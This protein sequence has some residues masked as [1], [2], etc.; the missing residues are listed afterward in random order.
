A[1][2]YSLSVD[3]G[4]EQ[5]VS[6]SAIYSKFSHK[7]PRALSTEE[8]GD[9]I[10]EIVNAAQ[11][12][13]E[14]GFDG[15]EIL[16]SAGYLI[17][18][19]LSPIKNTRTDRY[20]APSGKPTI[21][22]RLT[23]P[24]EL[25][26]KLKTT[27]GNQLFIGARFSGDD[28]VPGSNT[29][30]EKKIVAAAYDKAGIQYLN[31]T[32]GWHETRVPQIPMD[33]PRAAFAYLAKEMRSIVSI[34]VFASNRI[35]DPIL[36]ENL[37]Q[38]FYADAICFGRA[39]IA[40]PDFASKT[41][42]G[43]LDDIRTCVGCNQG[44]FDSVFK[45]RHVKCTVNPRTMF[46]DKYATPK[47]TPAPKKVIIIGA[48]PAGLEAA[49]QATLFGHQ[50]ILYEASH[51]LGGQL[52]V[53]GIPQGR[54]DIFEIKK[55]YRTQL[56]KLQIEYH[57]GKKMSAQEIL[58]QKPDVIFCSTGV[59]FFIPNIKGIDGS[60]NCNISFADDALAGDVLLGKKVVVIGGA[61]TGTETALWVAKRGAMNPN[62]AR[63]LSFH[64]ALPV[65]DAMQ[66]TY[67]GDREVYLLEIL[68][69]LGT[70]VG[71]STK[72]VFLDEL[73]KLQVNTL[74]NVK[75]IEFRNHSVYYQ[76]T[77]S[78]TPDIIHEISQ[79]DNF[80][81]ATGVR[82]NQALFNELQTLLKDA[83]FRRSDPPKVKK[84]GDSKKV[85][86][87]LDAIH[88]GFKAAYRLGKVQPE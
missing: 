30:L 85:G 18:Q 33:T 35:N 21:Q 69:K 65:E 15:V 11:N 60:Q 75:T 48:G 19:F 3:F 2:A 31:V 61:A 50:V 80:I 77:D 46:E 52:N 76:E 6:S 70:G 5:A 72:W 45:L 9:V 64:D 28:F 43:R 53:A 88:S 66:R 29:Y 16:S 23:F 54:E 39:L 27:V 22:E 7:T 32:G 8:V 34:P 26:K 59:E 37:L 87:I 86:T 10:D 49:H 12:A 62:V 79:V 84:L 17:D 83:E 24:L 56:D 40:D 74:V 20:G 55:Y 25:I 38:D 1:G 71:K 44:C 4:G 13:H 42:A 14:A 68:P 63:F 73:K 57:L 51:Q 47:S 67:R 82:P 81:L 41:A 36:A 58:A 78:E